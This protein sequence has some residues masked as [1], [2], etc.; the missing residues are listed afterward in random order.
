MSKTILGECF[1]KAGVPGWD[2]LF[3]S[4]I[5]AKCE[6]MRLCEKDEYCAALLA[7]ATTASIS[8]HTTNSALKF[9]SHLGSSVELPEIGREVMKSKLRAPR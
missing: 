1:E 6:L 9:A 5:C 7:L 4:R 2:Q 3:P 8:V